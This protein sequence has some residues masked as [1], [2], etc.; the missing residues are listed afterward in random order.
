MLVVASEYPGTQPNI[1]MHLDA[2]GDVPP[3]PMDPM[4]VHAYS[5]KDYLDPSIDGPGFL[6][7]VFNGCIRTCIEFKI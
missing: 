3:I 6:I 4:P 5:Q 7:S 1:K 2:T